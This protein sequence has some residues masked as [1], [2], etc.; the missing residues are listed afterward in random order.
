MVEA[1]SAT[2]KNKKADKKASRPKNEF[3]YSEM[4]ADAISTM[5]D[6]KGS[7]RQAILKYIVA[8]Y[9]LDPTKAAVYVR[10][11]IRRDLASGALKTAKESGK[12]AGHLKLGHTDVAK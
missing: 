7:S 12:G 3:T 5:A 9:K 11:A 6:K 10:N 2:K 8:K 4:I 1:R